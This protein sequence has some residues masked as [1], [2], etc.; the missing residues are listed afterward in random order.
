[1]PWQDLKNRKE[2]ERK[3]YTLNIESIAISPKIILYLF[4]R[5]NLTVFL[6][7]LILYPLWP[8]T[9]KALIP[10]VYLRVPLNAFIITVPIDIRT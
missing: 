7:L 6:I 9:K 8:N 5:Y 4:C 10:L 3:D 2:E 1:M